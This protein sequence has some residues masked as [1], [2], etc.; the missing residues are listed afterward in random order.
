MSP[1]VWTER[2]LY[3]RAQKAAA[4]RTMAKLQRYRSDV[5]QC[6]NTKHLQRFR[7]LSVWLALTLAVC[8]EEKHHSSSDARFSFEGWER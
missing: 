8:R 3:E 6:A 5:P 2:L 7:C 1:D 4:A